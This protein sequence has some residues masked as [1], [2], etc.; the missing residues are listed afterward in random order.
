MGNASGSYDVFARLQMPPHV[1][2]EG[3]RLVYGQHKDHHKKRD[4][5]HRTK[6]EQVF[7]S[8]ELDFRL[9]HRVLNRLMPCPCFCEQY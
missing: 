4:G 5:N 7:W 6:R 3:G 1:C 8:L 9:K 2:I